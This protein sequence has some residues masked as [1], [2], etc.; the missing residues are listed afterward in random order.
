M[1]ETAAERLPLPRL[2][3]LTDGSATGGRPLTDVVAAA[4]E[5]GARA[6][7]LREKHLPAGERSA[8]AHVLLDVMTAAG[9]VLI[10]AGRGASAAAA[11]HPGRRDGGSD[12]V[13]GD[14]RL[15]LAGVGVHLA[16]SDP[17]PGTRPAL[18]GRS[19]HQP[20]EVAPAR[21]EGCDYATLSPV[22]PSASKPGY[23]P[24]LGLGM[25]AGLPLPVWALGGVD[26]TNAA[27]C[28]QAG[29][30]GVAVMGAVMRSDDPAA[31]VRRLCRALDAVPPGPIETQPF[32]V[33]GR[34]R[35]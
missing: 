24:Q 21:E 11:A 22:F 12:G 8:L 34:Q 13:H 5:G 20:W 18:L 15:D 23:G 35:R 26:H 9:G 32:A 30:A 17:I 28:V 29:A 31:T 3:V 1:T 16:A 25:L 4:V 19:C 10:V 14:P 2:L 33:T 6:V 7:L 27:S